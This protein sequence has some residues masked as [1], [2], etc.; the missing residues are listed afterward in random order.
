VAKRRVQP[1]DFYLL[2]NV[3]DPQI[4]PDGKTVAYVVSWPDREK[5]ATQMAAFVAPTDPSGRA[6]APRR[7]TQ[8]D[9]DHSPRWSPDGKQIAFVSNRGEKNQLFVARLDGGEPRQVTD[10]PHGISQPA[11]SPDGKRIAYSARVGEHKDDKEKT[12]AEKNAPRVIRDLRYK[13]D[14][15][16]FFD[17]RRLHIFVVDVASGESKQITSGD[18]FDDQ[19]A[20][21]PNGKSIAFVS[22]RQ[23]KRHQRQWCGD[24][25]IVP[26]DGGRARKVTRSRGA[27][28]HP[29]FSP[30]GRQ[31]AYV[32]HEHGSGGFAANVHLMVVATAGG[33]PRPVSAAIDRSVSGWPAFASGRTFHWTPDGKSL[34]FLAVDRGTQ[35]V[36]RADTQGKQVQK[37]IGGD[38]QIDSF[39]LSPDGRRVAFTSMWLTQ[40]SELYGAALSGRGGE[41]NLSHANDEISSKVKLGR[42][43]RMPY[44][45]P[46]GLE[47]EAF[48]LYPPG[49]KK[50]R[51]AP[52]ALNVHGGPH[53]MH[54]SPRSWAEFHTLAARG[55]VVL[56][57]NPRGS[58]GYGESFTE[59]VVEDWGGKDY[60]D[61][62]RGVDVL[63]RRHIVDPERLY[64][65]GYSYGGFM[66]TWAVG[67]TDRFR[68]AIVGAPVSNQV[69]S[70]GT[71]DIPLFDISE[72]G[73]TPFDAPDEYRFRS[74]VTYLKNVNTP[75]L[76]LHHEGDLRCPIAQSEEIFHG[77]KVLG[78]EVEFVRYPGGFH[79][80]NT[81]AP[82]QVVDRINRI[83]AWYEGH[84]PGRRPAKRR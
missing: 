59:A 26:S 18:Y 31:I 51:L 74:P 54:P 48:V 27:A 16:G 52:L 56:L 19:P 38:R 24:V 81:H 8:R 71:G 58:G 62:V 47:V 61:I 28:A 33:A 44:R 40:P 55:Y 72:I 6:P 20:W 39:A 4:S 78:K 53:A 75:V 41:T 10:A 15:I 5:D 77:L 57:P 68:A 1:E 82:S 50:G 80:F 11:W 49:W 69:S 34:L 79:T 37:V 25:W 2:R 46:D 22:D 67:R 42:L 84:R 14:G 66:T 17:E 12:P 70:F 64:I 29:T 32:G 63:V 76:L 21:S 23:A 35:S 43:R 13:L 83:V 7:L 60:E 73:G 3:S 45:A 30:N 36:F 65:E 9:R